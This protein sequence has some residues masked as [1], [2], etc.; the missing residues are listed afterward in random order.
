VLAHPASPAGSA[1]TVDACVWVAAF[2]VADRFHR[3]SAGFLREAAR[4]DVRLHAPRLVLLEVRCAIAR[5]SGHA[6]AGA[7]AES[8]LRAAP[9]LRLHA[10]DERL[11]DTAG[12]LGATQ[13][14]RAADALYAACAA[15]HRA[16]LVT[17]DAELLARAG[18]RDPRQLF[19]P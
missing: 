4:R 3:E 17:W 6:E 7:R 11:L 15:L 9:F 16:P 8:A 10:M 19:V 18:A 13:R 5:R 14:L 12:E 1:Y 2:D